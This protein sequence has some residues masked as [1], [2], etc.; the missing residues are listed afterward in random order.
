MDPNATLKNIHD[1]IRAGR[2]G[3]EVDEWVDALAG[4]LARGGFEPDW[5]RFE[6]GT[7]YYRSRVATLAQE[8]KRA[9]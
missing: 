7:S 1:F 3:D 2:A 4:W 5:S 9:K 8:A 6:S